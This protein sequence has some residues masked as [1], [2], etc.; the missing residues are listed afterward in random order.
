MLGPDTT[1]YEIEE[2]V[3]ALAECSERHGVQPRPDVLRE[4]VRRERRRMRDGT[5][6]LH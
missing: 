2:I 6:D 4:W 3:A 5:S 1:D